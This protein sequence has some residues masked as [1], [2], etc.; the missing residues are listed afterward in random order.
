MRGKWSSTWWWKSRQQSWRRKAADPPSDPSRSLDLARGDAAEMQ[1][2]RQPRRG[3]GA[4]L[5]ARSR[6]T[7]QRRARGSARAACVPACSP[8]LGGS[9]TS[10]SRPSEARR[11][12]LARR[13]A[14]DGSAGSRRGA[15]STSRRPCSL[16]RTVE[17][18]EDR[19]GPAR[20]RSRCADVVDRAEAG[21]AVER[22]ARRHRAPFATRSPRRRAKGVTSAV[23]WSSSA[24]ISCCERRELAL[25]R[26]VADDQAAAA[27]AQRRRRGRPGIRAGTAFAGRMRD[28]RGAGGHR[29][30][31]RARR[32]SWASSAARSAGC[33]CRRRSRRNQTIALT[34]RPALAASRSATASSR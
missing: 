9:S 18:G 17:R 14:P 20:L 6:R 34:Y 32:G 25:R 24:P 1:V 28:G 27:R 12:D 7:P 33:S 29:G 31:R 16:P 8:P 21:V 11:R 5:V 19:V 3:A 22:R 15:P 26:A 13:R 23:K 2:G 30:R 4:E 10:C